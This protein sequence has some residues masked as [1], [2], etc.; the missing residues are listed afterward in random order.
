[1]YLVSLKSVK[2]PKVVWTWFHYLP[3]LAQN[4]EGVGGHEQSTYLRCLWVGYRF[5]EFAFPWIVIHGIVVTSFSSKNVAV[6]KAR[7]FLRVFWVRL[8]S[9]I[10]S[11]RSQSATLKILGKNL[12]GMP[13]IEPGA[14]GWEARTLT[15][16]QLLLSVPLRA[17]TT[18]NQ[19]YKFLSSAL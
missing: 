5:R 16:E 14:A 3:W 13:R 9:T 17:P 11:S 15:I 19:K 6:N 12:S 1:M 4:F 10:L 8:W 2:S 18:S 7:S